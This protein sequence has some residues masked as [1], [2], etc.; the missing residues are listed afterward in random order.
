MNEIFK[1]S[2]RLVVVVS[3][4]VKSR[5]SNLSI[6]QL[7]VVDVYCII[8]ISCLEIIRQ[9][10]QFFLQCLLSILAPA[11]DLR[12]PRAGLTFEILL[13]MLITKGY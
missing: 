11:K 1:S 8:S 7:P 9:I 10:I 13:Y 2:K 4:G 3:G 12:I 6:T 5:P